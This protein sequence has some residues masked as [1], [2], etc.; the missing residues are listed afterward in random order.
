V[1]SFARNAITMQASQ[2]TE[3]TD[4]AKHTPMMHQYLRIKV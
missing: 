3:N 1:A 4:I 2:L